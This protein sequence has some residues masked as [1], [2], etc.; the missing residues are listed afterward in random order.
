MVSLLPL[1]W[2]NVAEGIDTACLDSFSMIVIWWFAQRFLAGPEH[3]VLFCLKP[4]APC[5]PSGSPSQ[6]E[7]VLV[8][9]PDI[10]QLSL[11]PPFLFCSCVCFGLYSPFNCISFHKSSRQLSAF[12]LSSSG[13]ISVLLVLSAIY[14]FMKGS[15]SPDVSLCGWLGLKYRLTQ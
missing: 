2:I 7:D 12:S 15:L 3:T 4:S 5:V 13:L 11:P 9:V 6:G 14:L 8:Y 10:N 1:L